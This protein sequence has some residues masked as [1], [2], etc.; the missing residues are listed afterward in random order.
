MERADHMD[1]QCSRTAT[2]PALEKHI[3]RTRER[4]PGINPE[5]SL[6]GARAAD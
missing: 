6:E 5:A 1:V 3:S 4:E 2:A